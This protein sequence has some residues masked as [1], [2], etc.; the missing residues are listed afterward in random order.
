MP[1]RLVASAASH[2]VDRLLGRQLDHEPGAR[3][4]VGA[5]LDPDPS[6]V[7]AHVLVDERQAE[8]GAV[9]AGCAAR[10]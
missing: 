1:D 2:V 7:Q 6:A 3:L 9:A 4:A 8:P 10:H 5:I